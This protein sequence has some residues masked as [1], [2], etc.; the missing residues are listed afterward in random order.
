M[1]RV[2]M[3]KVKRPFA[4]AVCRS[5]PG[6][7]RPRRFVRPALPWQ[8]GLRKNPGRKAVKPCSVS[9]NPEFIQFF[10]SDALKRLHGC[11]LAELDLG[12]E[13]PCHGLAQ[14]LRRPQ[15]GFGNPRAGVVFLSPSPIDPQSASNEVFDEW[16]ARE[17]ALEHHLISET[18]TPY[19]RFVRAVF[20][21]LRDRWGQ[22]VHRH[23]GLTMAFHS[24]ATRCATENPD[25]V[26]DGAL[27][28]C[29]A[30]HLDGLLAAIAPKVIVAMGG[31]VARYFWA[32]S[33]AGWADWGPMEQLH[34]R[35]LRQQG[36]RS[37]ILS[38]HPYQH[39]L[40]LRPEVIARAL[41]ECLQPDDLRAAVP[42][43]A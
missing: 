18:V 38:I 27:G 13:S 8:R 12:P 28:Q 39:H 43:A 4:T 5:Q 24:W 21:G 40:D 32:S 2:S 30:R 33:V 35:V 10:G 6:I 25:R 9:R 1:V 36:G 19:F 16:V 14:P 22:P 37:V 31:P 11:A 26:T 34:G 7:R 41:A 23:D 20:N 17:E 42:Q 29:T 3:E 15:V